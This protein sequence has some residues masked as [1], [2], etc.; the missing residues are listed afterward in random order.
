MLLLLLAVV[1]LVTLPR[2]SG[3]ELGCCSH[4]DR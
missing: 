4:G 1:V 2:G 3:A